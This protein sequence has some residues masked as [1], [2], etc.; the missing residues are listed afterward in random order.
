MRNLIS[1]LEGAPWEVFFLTKIV[2]F[3]WVQ[4]V[5]GPVKQ[6]HVKQVVKMAAKLVVR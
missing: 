2:V 5:L 3:F 4:S 6:I 1:L